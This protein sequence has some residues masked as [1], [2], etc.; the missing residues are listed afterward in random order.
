MYFSVCFLLLSVYFLYLS[1][2]FL[3]L[4]TADGVGISHNPTTGKFTIIT[5]LNN[6][7]IEVFNLSESKI[8]KIDLTLD[9]SSYELDL[10]GNA[11]GIYVVN[12]TSNGKSSN[13][14]VIVE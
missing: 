9:K 5:K 2:Y 11:K 13:H 6:G 12:V 1:A 10:S 8:K 7:T 14:K 4:S 3:Y